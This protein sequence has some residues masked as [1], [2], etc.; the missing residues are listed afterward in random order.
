MDPAEFPPELLASG[1]RPVSRQGGSAADPAEYPA[2]AAC[3]WIPPSI[4]P[5]LLASQSRRVSRQRS[6]P[7]SGSRRVSRQTVDPA[8]YPASAGVSCRLSVQHQAGAACQHSP[9]DPASIPPE[10]L[11]SLV[12]LNVPHG[13]QLGLHFMLVPSCFECAL[14]LGKADTFV[15]L[16]AAN[17]QLRLIPRRASFWKW[18]GF[19]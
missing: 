3:Q 14:R 17:K 2:R 15:L 16:W 13:A 11:A 19:C 8:E 10:Q 5:E 1:C 9:V 12:L 6:L 18:L 7:V 4:P